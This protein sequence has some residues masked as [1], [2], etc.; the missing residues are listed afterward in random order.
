MYKRSA[1][2]CIFCG[3][4]GWCSS[5]GTKPNIQSTLFGR[6]A[7]KNLNSFLKH[8]IYIGLCLTQLI[9]VDTN[10]NPYF[11]ID[12]GAYKYIYNISQFSCDVSNRCSLLI[13]YFKQDGEGKLREAFVN[14][15]PNRYRKIERQRNQNGR[16]KNHAYQGKSTP[17]HPILLKEF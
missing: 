4:S 10:I 12:L 11:I 7:E 14:K 15:A 2:L 9:S 3:A 1:F 13:I 5:S 8:Y 17:P 6:L 16:Y